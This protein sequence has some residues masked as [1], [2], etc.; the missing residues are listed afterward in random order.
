MNWYFLLYRKFLFPSMSKKETNKNTDSTPVKS[1]P[2]D[3]IVEGVEENKVD[4]KDSLT[5]SQLRDACGETPH[6]LHESP[7]PTY[8]SRV[9]RGSISRSIVSRCQSTARK[10][11]VFDAK[12]LF[13]AVDYKEIEGCGSLGE[14]LERVLYELNSANDVN[15]FE[16][17]LSRIPSRLPEVMTEFF[18]FIN[19]RTNR[20]FNFAVGLASDMADEIKNFAVILETSL[21]SRIIFIMDK[22]PLLASHMPK[23]GFQITSITSSCFAFANSVWK[24]AITEDMCGSKNVVQRIS[25]DSNTSE[26]IDRFFAIP[27][28]A[29]YVANVVQ[30]LV[31]PDAIKRDTQSR[32]TPRT[33]PGVLED[34][35]APSSKIES[36]ITPVGKSGLSMLHSGEKRIYSQAQRDVTDL[37]KNDTKMDT[38]MSEVIACADDVSL[39]PLIINF[40]KESMASFGFGLCKTPEELMAAWTKWIS[41]IPAPATK[42]WIIAKLFW[43][44][45]S[46][47][48]KEA[49]FDL[50]CLIGLAGKF[51]SL[52]VDVSVEK[53]TTYVDTWFIQIFLHTDLP[54]IMENLQKESKIV[55]RLLAKAQ[56]F[57]YA[58]TKGFAPLKTTKD[59]K[60]ERKEIKG[61]RKSSNKNLDQLKAHP[62]T[63]KCE[64]C[65]ST[66]AGFWTCWTPDI[67]EFAWT[68]PKESSRKQY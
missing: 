17:L 14:L 47:I 11:K 50:C 66:C 23:F 55:T 56:T 10:I 51:I 25:F 37:I 16:T 22:N 4:D 62:L 59:N 65:Y 49:V 68:G 35:N 48:W 31:V 39:D 58:S 36:F 1:E 6:E 44:R 45:A 18:T 34:T 2:G 64:T 67:D 30:D 40:T 28:F 27:K 13:R 20:A 29:Q 46:Y 32:Y 42:K 60:E 8:K 9:S 33:F 61:G 63:C 52:C 5:S 19:T 43:Q 15:E 38:E 54:R 57:W 24:Q 41:S 21:F 12:G 26:A 3:F 53:S 7:K